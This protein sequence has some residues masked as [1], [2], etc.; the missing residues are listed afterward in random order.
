MRETREKPVKVLLVA[1][2]LVAVGVAGAPL[3][4]AS[5]DANDYIAFLQSHGVPFAS[6][7]AAIQQG[8]QVCEALQTGE[9]QGQATGDLE[10]RM[11]QAEASDYVAAAV[12]YLC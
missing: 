12:Q 2:A 7:D 10:H 5:G 1:A 9:S 8:I 4:Y 11:G 3:A 6:R